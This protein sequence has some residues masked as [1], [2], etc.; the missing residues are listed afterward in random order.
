MPSAG[1][2]HPRQTLHGHGV[3]DR[4][5][6]LRQ[7]YRQGHVYGT[8]RHPRPAHVVGRRSLPPRL[9]HCSSRPQGYRRWQFVV[10]DVNFTLLI[11][12]FTLLITLFTLSISLYS[13]SISL[14]TISISL[15]SISISLFTISISLFC[16]FNITFA[17]SIS[18]Y[19]ISSSH[20]N[21]IDEISWIFFYFPIIFIIL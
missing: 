12:L 20:I 17:I 21:K 7:S 14:F 3:G 15:Y 10:L 6:T 4:R 5:R 18:L 1:F 19:S 16:Y 13:I 11:S 8:R 9:R 2:R